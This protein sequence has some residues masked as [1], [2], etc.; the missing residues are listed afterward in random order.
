MASPHKFSL[1]LSLCLPS[2]LSLSLT[3]ILSLFFSLSLKLRR[4]ISRQRSPPFAL[5]C[6][7]EFRR[8][9]P[10][11]PFSFFPIPLSL[12]LHLTFFS[13]ILSLPSLS[14]ESGNGDSEREKSGGRSHSH[15]PPPLPSAAHGRQSKD[16]FSLSLTSSSLSSLQIL[17]VCSVISLA[18]R[19]FFLPLQSKV[20][21]PLISLRTLC[22]H[23][24]PLPSLSLSVLSHRG[25][26]G[27]EEKGGLSVQVPRRDHQCHPQKGVCNKLFVR[28]KWKNDK[29]KRKEFISLFVS[30]SNGS[31]RHK[32]P[33]QCW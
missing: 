6:R 7:Y 28:A 17:T 16:V 33:F 31:G 10:F 20:Q 11:T 2:H 1:S 4:S 5:S 26:G 21:L 14:G 18:G 12:S 30:C 15:P 3:L 9:S 29:A 8:R 23:P 32:D 19:S 24:S 25:K 27:K 13:H 22:S